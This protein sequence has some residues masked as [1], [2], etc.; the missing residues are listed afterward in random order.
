VS[1]TVTD[2]ATGAPIALATVIIT[3]EDTATKSTATG[4]D[5]HFELTGL[6]VGAA[7]LRCSAHGFA[8]REIQITVAEGS[9]SRDVSLAPYVGTINLSDFALYVPTSVDRVAG[10][11]LA[12]GGPDTRAFATGGA[13]GAP[14]PEVE[15]SLQALG[16]SL[17]EMAATYN[18]AILGTSQASMPN[19]PESDQLLAQVLDSLAVTSGRPELA[20]AN[21]NLILYGISGGGPEASGFTARNSEN[22]VGL[23][24]KVPV[25]A[26]ALTDSY[27]LSVPTYIVLAEQDAI[28]DNAAVTAVFEANRK[29]G[30]LWALA[31]ERG[32]PHHSL[33]PL[34]R[35][36]TVDWIAAIVK[37]CLPWDWDYGYP[38]RLNGGAAGWLGERETGTAWP[39]AAYPGD[40]AAASWLLDEDT[41]HDWEALVASAP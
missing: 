36:V 16:K 19:G 15:A 35:Q 10:I 3:V 6:R 27:A 24:L 33:S 37:N 25:R 7:T 23:F 9:T 21:G 28:V 38:C 39:W 20:Y 17:R 40:R 5:G 22:V 11:V 41:A 4:S 29:A 13:F 14:V 26:E 2:S 18:L 31:V 34:Q 30:G 1:G 8:T 12:L 32:V